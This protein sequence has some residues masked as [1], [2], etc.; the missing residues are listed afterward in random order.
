MGKHAADGF[1]EDARGRTVM[2]GTGLFGVDDM[3]LVEEVVVS[4]L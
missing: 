3:A 2:E 4:Q 1:E